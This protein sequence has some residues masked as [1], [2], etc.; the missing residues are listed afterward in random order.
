MDQEFLVIRGRL[1]DLAAALDRL[2]R[3]PGSCKEE[4][5]ARMDLIR[6]AIDVL[7]QPDPDRAETIQR[8]FSLP[9]EPGWM[10]SLPVRP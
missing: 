5:D 3:A 6:R 1:L 9:Y 10:A 8:L 7:A 4:H 2:D